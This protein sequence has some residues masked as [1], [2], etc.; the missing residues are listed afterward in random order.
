MIARINSFL[1]QFVADGF[2][3][4][5]LVWLNEPKVP[6]RL[7]HHNMASHSCG[8]A[9]IAHDHE[10]KQYFQAARKMGIVAAKLAL[11]WFHMLLLPDLAFAHFSLA[12]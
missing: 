3:L 6:R 11:A 12:V 5:P 10:P 2:T 4:N 1:S 7:H 8:N 9:H